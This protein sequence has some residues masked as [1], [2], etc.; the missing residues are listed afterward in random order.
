MKK[1]ILKNGAYASLIVVGIP[2]LLWSLF[3]G[4]PN[5]DISEIIGYATMIL[6]MAFVFLGIREY[7]NQELNGTISFGEALK[8]GILIALIP[9]FA[10]GFYDLIYVIYLD[11]GFYDNYYH[12]YTRELE[13]TLS[14]PELEKAITDLNAQKDF[15]MNPVIQFL[16]MFLTVFIIGFIASMVSSLILKKR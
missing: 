1:T 7:R 12:H 13:K 6:C 16:V 2:L 9:S 3:E 8:V 14:G 4:E 10:F 5:Y 11:P 15:F